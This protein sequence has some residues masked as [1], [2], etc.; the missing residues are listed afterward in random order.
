VS[1][2][3][4]SF[5]DG[6]ADGQAKMRDLLG[7]KGANLAEMT[8]LGI[9][10]P[11]G[12]TLSTDACKL[13][14]SSG[15][16]L[17]ESL[18][19]Q[20]ETAMRRLEKLR[21]KRFGDVADPL[22]VSVRS[23][24][25]FSM[26]GMMDTILN[27][28]LNDR[29]VAGLARTSGDRR[30]AFDSYRR[31]V[32]MYGS[33]VL[34]V[35]KDAFE[36][37]LTRTK[38][39]RGVKDD[40][41]LSPEDLEKLVRSFK[42]T[43]KKATG[44]AFPQDPAKQLWGAIAAVFRSWNTE[45]AQTYRRQYG[46]AEDLG[47]GVNVQVMVF[48]NLG[49]D[50]ATGVAFTRDPATGEDVLYGEYLQNAQGEDVVAGIRTPKPISRSQSE[51]DGDSF[52]ELM[53]KA[54]ADLQRVRKKLERHY[55]DMQDVEFTVERNKLYMLQTRTGKRTG[56]AAL[57]IAFDFHRSRLIDREEVIRRVEPN[58]L[59]HLLAPEFNSRDL[60][61]S[62]RGGRLLARGLPAGPGAASGAICF[63]AARAVKLAA[64][65][66]PVLLV[67]TETSPEDIGGMVAASGVVTSRGGITSHAA[68]VARGMGRPCVVGA[69]ALQ[70]DASAHRL[71]VNGRTLKEGDEMSMDGSTGE[72]FVGS[73]EAQPSEIQRVL[74][75]NSAKSKR[76]NL[77]RRY[78]KLMRWADGVRRLQVRTNAD[79]PEDSAVARAFGAQGI[80]LCR[81]EHMFFGE[82]R[83][84]AVRQVILAD[85]LKARA[86]G[87]SLLPAA[88]RVSPQPTGAVPCAGQATQGP[89]QGT[90]GE[91]RA[92][93]RA[94][95]DDGTPWMPA[96]DH[97]SGD[98]R[99]AGAGDLRGGGGL[100][101][102]GHS[103]LPRGHDPA[104]RNRR[105]VPRARLAHP[106]DCRRDP[107][108]NQ[109]EDRFQG[110]DDDR[111]SPGL[112]RG[113]TD[114][115]RG[116]VLLLRHERPDTDDLR[117]QP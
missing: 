31:F 54:Y 3:V 9:P 76:S 77:Y 13:Y 41:E 66:K 117:L 79:T 88:A 2:L 59:I 101:Q 80:G 61:A 92:V 14:F 90:A 23:G 111:G 34:G 97:L 102:E 42:A 65:G 27:L 22:L 95:P 8:R 57:N 50:C 4:Y 48:G 52:E 7:G 51:T 104:R 17:P 96:G 49:D 19:K 62:R 60:E 11:P 100:P 64:T 112:S 26:P 84:S 68:V 20:V 103:G 6:K 47:T 71:R 105:G 78:D 108:S 94:Q 12:F 15:N 93:A 18:R 70:V 10:V 40:T 16:K 87:L 35:D 114:R 72:V 73:M 113:G 110:R 116:G 82:D 46:I 99:D 58:M 5:G 24:A 86:K 63:T 21:G 106:A 53:P 56:H 25:K 89:G 45:R 44:R 115:R 91:S 85:D 83:I 38:R 67:R 33:V 75:A 107:T 36:D 30:F 37:Q 39:A 74:V 43:V 69:E 28:G 32:Q 109:A 55:R 98:L 81:T 29:T 1:K